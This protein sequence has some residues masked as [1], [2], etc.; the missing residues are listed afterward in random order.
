[1][2]RSMPG[3]KGRGVFVAQIASLPRRWLVIGGVRWW[4]GSELLRIPKGF[5]R[6]ARGC[7]A[8]LGKSFGKNLNPIGVA[9]H[10]LDFFA[11]CCNPFID[12]C[13]SPVA[14]LYERRSGGNLTGNVRRSQ[15]AATIRAAFAEISFRVENG[16]SR[17]PRVAPASQPRALCRCPVGACAGHLHSWP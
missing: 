4:P 1:M 15:T 11:N 14:A 12:L 3:A 7:E 2:N 5:R 16:F 9:A 10:R 6:P 17:S 8:T 13:K